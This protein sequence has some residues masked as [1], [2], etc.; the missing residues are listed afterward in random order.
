MLRFKY[1]VIALF[2]ITFGNNFT[3]GFHYNTYTISCD[4]DSMFPVFT[5]HN[6]LKVKFLNAN[7]KLKLEIG[8]IVAYSPTTIQRFKARQEG[9]H[10]TT[11]WILHRII[12]KTNQGYI[13]KGD[14]NNFV[15]ND[16]FG[17]IKPY[18]MSYKVY[19]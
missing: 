14:N 9:F 15:D 16:Y 11:T 7:D 3:N 12:N 5:C 18:Q 10:I 1:L 19:I 8:D 2:V 17:L 4:S 6:I 13:L